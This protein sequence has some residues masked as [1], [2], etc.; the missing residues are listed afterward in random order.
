[1]DPIVDAEEAAR[2]INSAMFQ[3]AFKDMRMQLF[4]ELAKA[5][6]RDT[7][8]LQLLVSSVKVLDGIKTRLEHRISTGKL[9]AVQIER[10]EKASLMSNFLR[11]AA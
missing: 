10:R 6:V 7:E 3:E 5:P 9:A 8:G 2:L 4:E 1:M 11:K